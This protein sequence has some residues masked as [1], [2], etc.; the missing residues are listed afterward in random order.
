MVEARGGLTDVFGTQLDP[1]IVVAAV[2]GSLALLSTV[3]SLRARG[4]PDLV[5]DLV[6]DRKVLRTELA[7]SERARRE[8]GGKYDALRLEVDGMKIQSQETEQALIRC[9]ERE[10]QG[11]DEIAALRRL[12]AG[13]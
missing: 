8:L 6:D 5:D 9:R 12:V 13:P 2:A 7:E 1:T 3:V 11:R 10:A 4:Y